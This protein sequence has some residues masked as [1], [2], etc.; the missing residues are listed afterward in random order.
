MA[1]CIFFPLPSQASSYTPIFSH[2]W[3][4]WEPRHCKLHLFP[5]FLSG[6]FRYTHDQPLLASLGAA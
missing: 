4:V 5:R 1:S 2:C 3:R 6:C